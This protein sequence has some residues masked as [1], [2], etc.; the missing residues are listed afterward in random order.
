MPPQN[1][2][3]VPQCLL[4]QFAS[5]KEQICVF[6]KAE[7]KEFVT[8]IRNVAAEHGFNDFQDEVG[9]E[10]AEGF[11]TGL[12]SNFASLLRRIIEAESIKFL[13]AEE[14]VQISIFIA[15]QQL[16]V[17]SSRQRLQSVYETIR[18][19]I[20]SHGDDPAKVE[21]FEELSEQQLH[22]SGIELVS[23]AKDTARYYL[24]KQWYL[25][26]TPDGMDFYI[27]DTPV[28]MHNDFEYPGRG[29]LGL[30]VKGI[31]IFMP[32]SPQLSLCF[33]C[34]HLA[35]SIKN[36]LDKAHWLYGYCG[37]LPFSI[38][39]LE[40][41]VRGVFRNQMIVL[42]P[43]NV[44]HQNSLQV[45]ESSRFVFSAIGNYELAKE[46]VSK[47]DSLKQPSAFRNKSTPDTIL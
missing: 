22:N 23:I 19:F 40:A 32:I 41:F 12:E 2:H 33:I 7:E 46:M 35:H 24:D 10:S 27:S 39:S 29:N 42:E 3:Y 6:D 11:F 25:A 47:H 9:L 36:A 26:K 38:T 30:D 8:S 17:K 4:R 44:V 34:S 1:Q 16:R 14:R 45:I 31:Q 43:E 5:N 13:N 28:T 37:H 15:V 20:V 18:S 21:G